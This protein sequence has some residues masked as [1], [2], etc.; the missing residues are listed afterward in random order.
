MSENKAFAPCRAL[1]FVSNHVP[2]Q[3]RYIKSRQENLIVTCV[4]K[5]FHTY[6]IS[7]FSLLSVSGLHPSNIEC[8]AADS[9][10]V[11]T[12]AG[13]NIYAWRRGTELKHTYKGH[14]H[15]VKHLL[16]F[17]VHLISV[18]EENNLKIWDI[19]DES[20]YSELTFRK[21]DF[22]ITSVFHPLTY[23]NKILLGSDQGHLQLWNIR[24]MKLIYAFKGWQSAV[25]CIAQSTAVDVVAIGLRNGDI[26]I[27]DLKMDESIM[28]LTQEWGTVTSISFRW[29]DRPIMTSGSETGHI[30][31]WDLEKRRVA[32]QV[33]RAHEGPVT[34]MVC[35]PS[36]PLMLTSSPDNRLKLWIFDMP[37]GGARLLR[38]REGHS[39][40]PSYI[41]FHD[42]IGHN[43]LSAAGDSTLRIFNTRTEQFNKSLGKASHNRK[44]SKKR[45]GI[46]EDSHI[47]PPIVQFTSE[48]AREK[49]WDNIASIHLGLPLVT[50][51]SYSK[52]KMGDFKLLPERLHKKNLRGSPDSV[53]TC[54]C[55][56]RCGNFVI[57]GYSTG[58]VDRFNIQSGIWKENYG[59]E[60]AHDSPVRGVAVDQLNQVTV[61]GSTKGELTFWR[62][63]C[64]G[65]KPLQNLHL[66]ESINFF[67]MNHENSLLAI[68]MED[69]TINIVDID[70]KRLIR[71]LE[72]HTGQVTDLTFSPDSRWLISS[73]MDS[74]V[75]IWDIPSS[76]LIDQFATHSPCTSLD[77][78]P[79]GETLATSHVDY[80]GIFLWSNRTLFSKVTLRAIDPRQEAK[81]VSLPECS[82]AASQEEEDVQTEEDDE[83]KSPEQICEE[84]ITL[85]GLAT[86]RWL[87]LLDLEQ[88]KQRNKLKLPKKPVKAP[89][90]LP[91]I[92]SLTFQFDLSNKEENHVQ[93]KII[94]PKNFK[95]YTAFGNLLQ[96]TIETNDFR[97]VLEKIMSFGPSAIDFEIKS[98][99]G[100]SGGSVDIMLQFLKF[101]DWM[102]CT[103]KNYEIASSYYAVFLKSHTELI[104]NDDRLREYFHI[105]EKRQS[106]YWEKM[107]EYMMYTLSA[108]EFLKTM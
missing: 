72:G 75:K 32:S 9:Y 61:T 101:I 42:P 70:V 26:V 88:I 5:S 35:L 36:E 51:W 74:S 14:E 85:S 40:P 68:A 89:F 105:V 39:A 16:P 2:L 21:A 66:E 100:A 11:Y 65:S 99:D 92:P 64:N 49:D 69:F 55:M 27:H 102:F 84:L 57:I 53:A 76:T 80:L 77:M 38:I 44:A 95:N 62:F 10:H 59:S 24:E 108:I 17:G 103:K 87:N 78:S 1:G 30:V 71:R 63:K 60:Y 86:S 83:Y 94:C 104:A 31:M 23:I 20:L 67:R 19:K 79:T 13:P 93:S 54:L 25:T 90:F 73:S 45:K 46:V 81:L 43:I 56:T 37:D 7:H 22:L 12:G 34:G 3:V 4:G 58:H 52:L 6:G 107:E 50:T 91:T 29:D 97:E 47:M 82:Q 28:K 33:I 8:M 96:A 48:T 41:R 18:D 98:L 106:E 15:N